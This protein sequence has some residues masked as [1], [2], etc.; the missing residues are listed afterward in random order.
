MAALRLFYLP[1]RAKAEPI[2]MILAAGNIPYENVVV[3]LSE[4]PN[5]KIKREI[6]PFGQLPSVQL[7]DGTMLA[8]SSAIISYVAKLAK[9][10]PIVTADAAIA[11]MIVQLCLNEMN[12]INP[13][14]NFHAV[15]TEIWTEAHQTYFNTLPIHLSAI[16]KLAENNYLYSGAAA[17]EKEGE[18]AAYYYCKKK[19]HHGDFALFHI[20][21]N[22]LTVKPDALDGYP[23]VKSWYAHML[24]LPYLKTYVDTRPGSEEVGRPSSLIKQ[25]KI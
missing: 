8:Q 17:A 5:A 1:L 20:I 24:M 6:C 3:P 12:A 11:D 2:R 14:L 10:Y 23:A 15:N 22:T 9:V 13:I 25:L 16:T 19:P 7:P 4:W 18:G 21:N